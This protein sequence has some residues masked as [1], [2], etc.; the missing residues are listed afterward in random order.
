MPEKVKKKAERSKEEGNMRIKKRVA[1]LEKQVQS[2][3]LIIQILVEFSKSV[4]NKEG[5]SLLSY[6]QLNSPSTNS[7]QK[8]RMLLKQL[9]KFR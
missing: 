7:N 5:L 3:Q 1:N 6:Q 4:A 8:I 2:Q 9:R